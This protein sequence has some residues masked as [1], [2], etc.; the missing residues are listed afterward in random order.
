M[1]KIEKIKSSLEEMRSAG[2]LPYISKHWTINEI[3]DTPPEKTSY[4]SFY[5]GYVF[6]D[7]P[8]KPI[9]TPFDFD[10]ANR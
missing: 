3:K 4:S 6:T 10:D 2:Q 5:N 1:S 8:T 9:S 7:L